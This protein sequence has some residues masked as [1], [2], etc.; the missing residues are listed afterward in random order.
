[1]EGPSLLFAERRGRE[2][3][4]FCPEAPRWIGRSS[5]S[6]ILARY[7]A[8]HRATSGAVDNGA[9]VDKGGILPIAAPITSPVT[10]EGPLD[11]CLL[12]ARPPASPNFFCRGGQSWVTLR[13]AL[14]AVQLEK[15]PRNP[16]KD[17]DGRT[18]PWPVE[19]EHE[20][21]RDRRHDRCDQMRRAAFL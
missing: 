14:A 9:Y 1:M 12:T 17:D 15:D 18:Q 11:R 3:W 13:A 16:R 10:P 4:G 8:P 5:H 7:T 20:R 2:T 6:P 19:Q 21:E